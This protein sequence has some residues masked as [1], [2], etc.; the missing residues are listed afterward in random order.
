MYSDVL[1]DLGRGPLPRMRQRIAQAFAALNLNTYAI[2]ISG[3]DH[4]RSRC[5]GC[6]CK[7][8]L[9]DYASAG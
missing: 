2:G 4:V 5:R 8:M 9:G 6:K 3:K 7:R 1:K